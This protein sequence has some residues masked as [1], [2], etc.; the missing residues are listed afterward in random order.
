[1]RRAISRSAYALLISK[2]PGRIGYPDEILRK[3]WKD[4]DE[5]ARVLRAVSSPTDTASFWS[6]TP[7]RVLPALA[8]ASA[9]SK[10]M[11][12]GHTISL[13]GL[14]SV[15]IP[16][17]PASGRPSAPMWVAEGSPGPV[18]NMITS[19]QTLGPT[20]KLLIFAMLSEELE[21]ASAGTA[22]LIIQ[23][24]LAIATTQ[25]LDAS[26]FSN[27]APTTAAP[28]GLLYNV[29]PLTPT[30]TA[31]ATSAD[32]MAT[33]IAALTGVMS[34]AGID[35]SNVILICNAAQATKIEILASPKFQEKV[36]T[37]VAVPAGTIIAVEP[38]GF[39]TAYGAEQVTVEASRGALLHAEDTTPAP[40]VGT[41]GQVA[42]PTRSLYQTGALGL[43]V[44][45]KATWQVWPGAVQYMSGV[46]W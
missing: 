31:G 43:K 4:D 17:I 9:A 30:S 28:A 16:M 33:D 45:G 21:A 12:L 10:L 13:D 36:F 2:V 38:S 26:L 41:G 23:E 22:T 20:K 3:H 8:P 14:H 7:N 24:A 6:A 19:S 46:N 29:T 27:S 32:K 18:Y 15:K 34:N 40:I 42:A 11:Q 39:W 44:R 35:P 1:M 25:Q 5:S 37:S